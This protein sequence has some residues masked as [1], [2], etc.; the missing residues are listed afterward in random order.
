MSET[1]AASSRLVVTIEAGDEFFFIPGESALVGAKGVFVRN[2]E[3]RVGSPAVIQVCKN[4]RSVSLLGVVRASYR[5]FGTAVD[6]QAIDV[7]LR[8]E[9]GVAMKVRELVDRLAKADPN[10]IVV[11]SAESSSLV[12]LNQRLGM[13]QPL[14]EDA[15]CAATLT[16]CDQEFLRLLRVRF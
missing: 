15:A 14:D 7:C 1:E 9:L 6:L 3:L 5:D 8:T 11:I 12:L 4:Q 2:V 10:D 13:F 16:Q